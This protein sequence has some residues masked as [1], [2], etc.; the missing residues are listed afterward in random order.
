MVN[1]I[2]ERLIDPVLQ[3]LPLALEPHI[4]GEK[5]GRKSH[6]RSVSVSVSV[7]VS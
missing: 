4:C 5:D 6:G 7:R 2:N 1:L 3:S